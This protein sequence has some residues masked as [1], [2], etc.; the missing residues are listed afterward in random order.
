MAKYELYEKAT[1]VSSL[2]VPILEFGD[3]EPRL[4][5]KWLKGLRISSCQRR[6]SPPHCGFPLSVLTVSISLFF[7]HHGRCVNHGEMLISLWVASYAITGLQKFQCLI[8]YQRNDKHFWAIF[9]KKTQLRGRSQVI[10]SLVYGENG[11]VPLIQHWLSA[12]LL[13]GT[14]LTWLEPPTYWPLYF[15]SPCLFISPQFGLGFAARYSNPSH[16]P[17]CQSLVTPRKM[18]GSWLGPAHQQETSSK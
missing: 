13:D 17:S 16:K 5:V 10:F 9:S 15:P 1:T 6:D 12:L 3:K 7:V 2:S 18:S 4:M 8:K 14:Y 11:N